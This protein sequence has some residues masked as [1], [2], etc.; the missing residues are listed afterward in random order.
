MAG[1]LIGDGA[2]SI[3]ST[4]RVETMSKV[5]FTTT[6]DISIHSTARVETYFA[7]YA[8]IHP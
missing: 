7:L 3:H 2:I 6:I 5:K 1:L 4:A 8:R